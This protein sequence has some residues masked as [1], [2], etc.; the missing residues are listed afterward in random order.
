MV[1][2]P[3]ILKGLVYCVKCGREM[4]AARR[5]PKG[6]ARRTASAQACYVHPKGEPSS[7]AAGSVP[8]RGIHDQVW[9]DLSEFFVLSDTQKARIAKIAAQPADQSDPSGARRKHLEV[10]LSNLEDGF[11]DGVIPLERYRALKQEIDDE[12]ASL[13]VQPPSANAPLT[14]EQAV[15]RLGEVTAI[16]HSQVKTNPARVNRIFH[17]MLHAIW[18]DTD[19]QQVVGYTPRNWCVS[20]FPADKVMP[21]PNPAP[22]VEGE[23]S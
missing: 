22:M 15:E 1:D 7:H 21:P 12:L 16:I 20:S 10:R 19:T 2:E 3:L 6:E 4:A 8:A 18:L 5:M 14:E 9:R 13:P 11:L 17:S 23:D